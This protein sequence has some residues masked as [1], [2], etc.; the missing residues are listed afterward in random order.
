VTNFVLTYAQELP[1]TAKMIGGGGI[2]LSAEEGG[3]IIFA[4]REI[5]LKEALQE[6]VVMS[7]PMR[8]LCAETCKGLCSRC[9]ANLN[10]G[11]CGCR[12][13]SFNIKFAALKDLKL[14][15]K[16]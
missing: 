12:Q 5:D 3:L 11:D 2:E 9:G 8:P 7:I 6:Q 4:G 10:D 1:E 16:E 15:Q 14:N 13:N